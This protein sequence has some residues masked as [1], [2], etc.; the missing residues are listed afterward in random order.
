MKHVL[1][2]GAGGPAGVNFIRSLRAAP[3][4]FYIIAADCNRHHLAWPDADERHVV[5][6]VSERNGNPYFEAL[7]ELIVD[8]GPEF[9]H[10]QVD[11]EVQF[12]GKSILHV[13]LKR[14]GVRYNLPDEWA[15]N[16]CADKGYTAKVWSDAGLV[17]SPPVTGNRTIEFLRHA[18]E[19]FDF[20][21]WVRA[22]HGAGARASTLVE[23]ENMGLGWMQYWHAR[24]D[25]PEF[26]A[27]EYYPGRDYAWQSVWRRGKLLCSQAR[28]RL[29]YIY[30]H[31]APSGR[32]GTPTVAKTVHNEAVNEIATK[33]VQVIDDQAT[34]I[35]CVD[36]RED[37]DGVPR[38][39]EINCGRFFTTSHFFTEAGCNM[40]YIYVKSA[41]DELDELGDLLQ[42]NACPE[43]L[44][45][46]RHIDC[47]AVMMTEEELDG[48]L[49]SP[50]SA[51]S[52]A[53]ST[54]RSSNS[55]PTSRP[56]AL[57]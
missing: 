33:A 24:T 31:L 47:P 32:T 37:K 39:T 12:W 29:E 28:E 42:Y 36:L 3:E 50:G 46:M 35:F 19:Q 52:S 38:P 57:Y 17:S 40:P 11:A 20:P 43:G 4:P 56:C 1:V 53:T 25:Y 27:H 18:A 21:F 16:E 30:P 48:M 10:C 51:S 8:S 2:T 14:L 55:G 15:I 34:G 49:G 6:R 7:K 44:L 9:L 22:T 41:F 26:V 5:P 54:E 23:T 13:H 45:W